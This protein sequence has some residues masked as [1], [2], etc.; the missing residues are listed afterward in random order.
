MGLSLSGNDFLLTNILELILGL[1]RLM[2]SKDNTLK[3]F[4]IDHS[5]FVSEI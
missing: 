3:L 1:M 5:H 4:L 2:W